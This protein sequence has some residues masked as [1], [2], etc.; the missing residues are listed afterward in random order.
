LISYADVFPLLAKAIPDFQATPED[1]RE[2]TPYF[3]L[4][5]MV[6]FICRRAEMGAHDDSKRFSSLMETL[7]V[8]GDADI[9][10]LVT[11]A[12]ETLWECQMR[13]QIAED[14]GPKTF[15]R[16][17]TLTERRTA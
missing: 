6:Q 16:W 15:D 7:I 1:W 2:P 5:E 9:H 10:D 14:F 17:R 3:F 12:M 4:S 8:E 11:D 13:D